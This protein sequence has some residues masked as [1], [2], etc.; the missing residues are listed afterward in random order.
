MYL[1][2]FAAIS[3]AQAPE[4]SRSVAGKTRRP[5]ALKSCLRKSKTRGPWHVLTQPISKYTKQFHFAD[6]FDSTSS[7]LFGSFFRMFF[8]IRLQNPF[9]GGAVQ[10]TYSES[11]KRS[12]SEFPLW[13]HWE[14]VET[15]AVQILF[16][17]RWPFRWC[18]QQGGC[19]SLEASMRWAPWK[20]PPDGPWVNGEVTGWTE[21]R[22]Q[23]CPTSETGTLEPLESNQALVNPPCSMG[24]SPINRN[25][26]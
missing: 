13:K 3:C 26:S 12:C 16:T 10:L 18:H 7:Y 15:Q 2:G 21:V 6:R 5:E 25:K 1:S 24:R 9:F 11:Q 19:P 8:S 17:Q 23:N 20:G 22:I 14:T 4:K